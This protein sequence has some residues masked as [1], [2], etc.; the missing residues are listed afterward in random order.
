MPAIS[1]TLPSGR[2][3]PDPAHALDAHSAFI[4]DLPI[5]RSGEVALGSELSQLFSVHARANPSVYFEVGFT[6]A[7]K[8][9]LLLFAPEVEMLPFDTRLNQ[10]L[11]VPEGHDLEARS[12]RRSPHRYPLG[13]VVPAQRISRFSAEAVRTAEVLIPWSKVTNLPPFSAARARR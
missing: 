6:V 12:S 7:K 1:D 4:E 13:V 2:E 8:K 5:A 11:R 9:D 10:W 3:P